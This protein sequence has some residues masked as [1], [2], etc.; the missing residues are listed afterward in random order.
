VHILDGRVLAVSV[1]AVSAPLL[2]CWDKKSAQSNKQSDK[3]KEQEFFFI[4]LVAYAT[5]FDL[6]F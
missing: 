6:L 4:Y 5:L 1:P 3:E 2:F